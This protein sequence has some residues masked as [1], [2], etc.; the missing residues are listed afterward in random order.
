MRFRSHLLSSI[1]AALAVFSA[2][3]PA[4]AEEVL[5]DQIVAVVNEDVVMASELEE[6]V[7]EIYI[8][9]KNSGTEVPPQNV[10][11]PQVLERLILEQLQLSRGQRAGV[12]ISDDEVN[13]AMQRLAQS[14]GMSMEDMV[15][16]AHQSGVTLGRLREQLRNEIIIKRVQEGS[17]NRRIN[18]S[19]QEIDNFLKSE[20]GQQWSSPDVNLG[21]IILPLSAGAPRDEVAM[22]ENKARELFEKLQA[23]ADFKNLAIANSAGQNALQ[24]GDLGWRKTAQLPSIFIT[25][26]EKLSPGEV[27][28]PIRSDAGYHILKLYD[29]RGGGE[30]IVLQHHARHILIKPNEIRTEDETKAMLEGIRADILNGANFA[31]LAKENSEDIGTAM[32]GGDLGWSLPGQFVPEFEETMNNIELNQVS[33]PFRS[34]FGWHIL[35]VTERRQQDFSE[36]LRRRQAENV[37][38]HRKFEE[39][40]QIWLQEIRDEAFV[41]IKL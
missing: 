39:E 23:G 9:I 35:Q 4:T 24:G 8:R 20:E 15:E 2:S 19:E 7:Q 37:L 10:L 31:E 22:V 25:A 41:D 26:V 12:R 34:Q 14:R 21:H 11:V 28:V 33:E 1:F 32:A 40:L 6:R 18:I 13:Q 16:Q 29:R 5:L 38:R 30:K 17:V 36:D 3:V 27:S